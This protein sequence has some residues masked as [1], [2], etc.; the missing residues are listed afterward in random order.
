MI[1]CK[2]GSSQQTET[3]VRASVSIR[4]KSTGLG[5]MALLVA[6]ASLA[7]E[8]APGPD[9]EAADLATKLSNP[10]ANLISVPF[11]NNFEFGGGPNNHGFRYQLNLQPV[12]PISISTN[13]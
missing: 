10:V 13:W 12:I 4:N 3:I 11:Q 2:P 6:A 5:V 1:Y 7:Q 9:D 8:A